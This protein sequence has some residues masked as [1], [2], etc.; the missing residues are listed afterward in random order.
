M[1]DIRIN[2]TIEVQAVN[3][4]WVEAGFGSSGSCGTVEQAAY[5]VL[6]EVEHRRWETAPG[7]PSPADVA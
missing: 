1:G 7:M 3:G 6:S 2:Y 4:D 5:A